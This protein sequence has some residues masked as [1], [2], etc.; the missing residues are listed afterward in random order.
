MEGCGRVLPVLF[1]CTLGISNGSTLGSSVRSVQNIL[2]ELVDFVRVDDAQDRAETDGIIGMASGKLRSLDLEASSYE[3]QVQLGRE[4][5]NTRNGR[6]AAS[7]AL[8]DAL[9]AEL[10]LERA[11][12]AMF[13]SDC[14]GERE[15]ASTATTDR[16]AQ[17]GKLGELMDELLR[18][19]SQRSRRIRAR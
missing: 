9:M 11:A 1:L 8:R 7:G 12:A 13:A 16:V 15:S 14:A 3:K 19:S 2:K 10:S 4:E 17:S 18:R 6:V 5:M